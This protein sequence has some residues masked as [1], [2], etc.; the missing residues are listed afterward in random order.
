MKNVVYEE[1]LVRE[2]IYKGTLILEGRMSEAEQKEK[3]F[4]MM[5]KDGVTVPNKDEIEIGYVGADDNDGL[6]E[7]QTTNFVVTHVYKKQ[8]PY[9]IKREEAFSCEYVLDGLAITPKEQEKKIIQMMKDAGVEVPD[10]YEIGYVGA[11]DN[12][13]LS[14]TQTS[15]AVVYKVTKERVE[16]EEMGEALAIRDELE[17]LKESI[18]AATSSDEVVELYSKVSSID[19]KIEEL[20]KSNSRDY[21]EL[22]RIVSSLDLEI[23]ELEELLESKVEKLENSYEKIKEL[24]GSQDDNLLAQKTEEKERLDSIRK[25]IDDLTKK[26]D[27]TKKNRKKAVRD[28]ETAK[29]LGLSASEYLEITDNTKKKKLMDAILDAKGLGDII[30]IPANERNKEQRDI[31]KAARLEIKNEIIDS[32]RENKETSVLKLIEALYGVETEVQLKGK[33]RVLIVKQK[34][35]DNIRD[36]AKQL[37]EK[38]R[39]EAQ[40][41]Y[42]PGDAPKDMVEV[43]SS[44][45]SLVPVEEKHEEIVPVEEKHEE[46]VPVEEKHEEIVPVE[47]KHEEVTPVDEVKPVEEKDT[48]VE[49]RQEETPIVSEDVV[50]NEEGLEELFTFFVDIKNQDNVYVRK[51]V[52]ERFNLKPV[53]AEHVKVNG[54]ECYQISLDDARY[55]S[56]NANNSYSPYKVR[57]DSIEFDRE[58]GLVEQFTFFVDLDDK[59]KVYARKYVF[60]RFGIA[61]ASE[62]PVRINGE[63]CYAVSFDDIR[64]ISRLADNDYSPYQVNFDSVDFNINKKNV[65]ASEKPVKEFLD[66]F[67]I[68][69]DNDTD[70]IYVNKPVFERFNIDEFGLPATIDNVICFEISKDDANYILNN[71]NNTYSPYAVEIKKVKA[72]VISKDHELYDSVEKRGLVDKYTIFRD[73]DS[74]KLYVRKPVFDRFHANAIGEEVRIKGVAGYEISES[75]AEYILSNC[76][77]NYSPYT[78]DF[79]NLRVN[80]VNN[81]ESLKQEKEEVKSEEIRQES[82]TSESR[83]LTDKYTIIRD[84]LSGKYFAMKPVF[85]RFNI[86]KQSEE[87]RV[88]GVACHEISLSDVEFIKGNANNSYSPYIVEEKTLPLG[89]TNDNK[90][91]KEKFTLYKDINSDR[92]FANKPVINRFNLNKDTQE[93]RINDDIYNELDKEDAKFIED[94]ANNSYSP[95]EVENREIPL[96]LNRLE[97][98]T[99]SRGVTERITLYK[100][101]H[102]DRIFAMKPVFKRFNLEEVGDAIRINGV[103]CH[104]I[105]PEDALFIVRNSDN[106]YSPYQV[107]YHELPLGLERLENDNK[108]DSEVVVDTPRRDS[109]TIYRE[110]ETNKFYAG[111]S[112][113][114]RFRLDRMSGAI[115]IDGDENY[116]ISADDVN[117]VVSNKNNKYSPYDVTI[118]NITLE[119]SKKPI[120]TMPSAEIPNP[121]DTKAVAEEQKDVQDSQEEIIN[122]FR[123]LNDNDQVYAGNDVLHRFGISPTSPG[124]IING[125]EAHKISRDTDQIINSIAKMSHNP[126]MIINYTD[127]YLEKQR[128]ASTPRPHVEEIIDKLTRG[129]DIRPKD[130]KRYRASNIK[131]SKSFRSELK[132]GN[133]AYNIVHIVPATLRAGVN[134]FRKLSGKIVTTKRARNAMQTIEERLDELTD[135]ELEVLFDEYKGSQLKTDMNNQINPLIL[136]TIREYGLRKVAKLNDEIRVNYG[137]LFTILGEIKVLEE[138]IAKD[139]TTKD[140]A[141]ILN[142]ER[143]RML[144]SAAGNVRKIL[145]CRREANNLLSSGV[146]GIEEDFKAVSTKLSYVG[147]R[148]GKTKKFDNELQHK[149]GDFGRNL[150][151]SLAC[152]DAEGIVQSFM[153]LESCYYDNTEIRGSLVGKRSV[154]SKYYTPVAEQFDYRDDPF[155]RDLLSTIAISSAAVSAINAYRIHQIESDEISKTLQQVQKTGE[156]IAGKRD[157]IRDGMEAQAHQDVLNVANVHERAAL[158]STGWRFNGAYRAADDLG[159]ATYNQFGEQVNQSINQVCSDYSQGFITQADALQ[160]MADISNNAQATLNDV[161]ESSLVI[162]KDYAATHPQF[163]LTAVQ[164]SMEYISAHPTAIADM[165]QAMVDITNLADTLSSQNITH[166]AS[167]AALPSD[168]A[169]TLVC[170]ASSAA[171]A[172][173]VTSKMKGFNKT[174]STYTEEIAGMMDDYVNDED[175][176]AARAR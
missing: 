21:E 60:E 144:E 155:M 76:E 152:N 57:F 124:I 151:T 39:G 72:E 80:K 120:D 65:M 168:M 163:D 146:H 75:D 67:V 137:E 156:E 102:S 47:E 7:T 123:D 103:A 173:Y 48:P 147:L 135:E 83:G 112:V 28:L 19:S 59:E 8:V 58:H 153:G 172:T 132:S 25:T 26:I 55:V 33:Q 128:D 79:V 93:V 105:N 62:K 71:A 89:I 133:F 143:K 92:L 69:L 118:K 150:N 116:E 49:E 154:G 131:V 14:E 99:N 10:K 98:N 53:S 134:F 36:N 2:E 42:V 162:L 50:A 1:E 86:E 16:S 110:T 161:V 29:A 4:E 165:N 97:S 101:I 32:K 34:A 77:N 175:L 166:L 91:V 63:L 119:K 125:V 87:V 129:L 22:E 157:V 114:D 18:K 38:I 52:F 117:Y 78:V 40:V 96:G 107:V 54:E 121:I 45:T 164:E 56:G 108:L 13:G 159:H 27:E 74:G 66:K 113:I 104:E 81:T 109:Y 122:L 61:K 111:D 70:K 138:E 44:T 94:N 85:V 90:D 171:L 24:M 148:F 12:D 115:S 23:N 5:R 160:R 6:S 126:K 3:I 169:S 140:S 30:A 139:D 149:L 95:Y 176:T 68:Y 130:Q 145:K 35:L 11:D 100:D 73:V 170:A 82:L 64:E 141:V 174:K 41:N 46:I 17:S 15:T 37:P 106:S 84:S 9:Q 20:N 158:D 142:S 136:D 88:N 167:L 51:Y 43:M 31:L 127:V